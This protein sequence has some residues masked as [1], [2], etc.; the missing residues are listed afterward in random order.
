MLKHAESGFETLEEAAAAVAAYLPDRGRMRTPD[1]LAN[2]LSLKDGRWYWHWD[3]K[4]LSSTDLSEVGDGSLAPV[5]R[6]LSLPTLLVRGGRS[7]VLDERKVQEFL[8]CVPH[9][10]HRTVD[11]AGHMI[12]GDNNDAFN[13]VIG[14]FLQS[15]RP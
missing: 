8:E 15:L 12:A 11:H 7:D 10:Q 6:R 14:E 4:I 3:P 9:A 5:A 2:S 13:R 1:E